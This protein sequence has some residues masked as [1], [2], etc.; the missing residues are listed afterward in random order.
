MNRLEAPFIATLISYPNEIDKYEAFIPS[1]EV[2]KHQSH[3]EIWIAIKQLREQGIAIEP[4]I[5]AYRCENISQEFL[6]N[7]IKLANKSNLENYAKVV[8]DFYIKD[9][10]EKEINNI[11]TSRNKYTSD[12]MIELA[13]NKLDE[14]ASINPYQDN[15]GKFVIPEVSKKIR[16]GSNIIK[17][18][19]EFMD[20]IAG[21]GTRKEMIAIAARPGHGKTTL[22][23]NLVKSLIEAGHI[24]LVFN[25][26]MSNEEFYKKLY[27]LDSK[28]LG[29]SDLRKKELSEATLK[30]LDKLT[31]L[32]QEKYK[33]LYT[34]DSIRNVSGAVAEIHRKK[35]DFF[36][37]DFIQMVQSDETAIDRKDGIRNIFSAY[38]SACKRANSHGIIISQMNRGV[39][40]RID[41][42]PL[43]SDFADASEIEWFCETAIFLQHKFKY[44]WQEFPE[45]R[46]WAYCLKARYGKVGTYERHFNGEKCLIN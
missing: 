36:I 44:D 25:R 9:L 10:L 45:D 22:S 20:D 3:K 6:N 13:F 39:E 46:I 32:L 31:P 2:F 38:S 15:S 41:R 24:G 8:Y 19:I 29:S 21:G 30:E 26:E 7:L 17:Y 12:K 33:N 35:P 14:L 28:I 4:N 42:I 37:D 16:A 27:I 40:S 23:A 34:Y 18:G 5:V 11:L 1:P 43:L